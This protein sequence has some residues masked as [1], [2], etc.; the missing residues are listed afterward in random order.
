MIK[1]PLTSSPGLSIRM[2]FDFFKLF[3]FISCFLIGDAAFSQIP[4]DKVENWAD[5]LADKNDFDGV[6]IIGLIREIKTL[7]TA[8]WCDAVAAIEEH[9]SSKL[10]FR[11]RLNLL[12]SY[13]S[14]GNLPCSRLFDAVALCKEALKLAYQL[15]DP[16]LIAV[17]NRWVANAY[18]ELREFGLAILH[19][20]L[21]IEMQEDLG[22]QQFR[23][24]GLDH[25]MIGE[26]LYHA[27]EY[28]LAIQA[29][30]RALAIDA[31]PDLPQMDSLGPINKMFSWNTIGLSHE[32]LGQYDS[33][34]I[35]FRKAFHY[36]ELTNNAGWK[37]L[38]EGNMGDIYFHMAKYDSAE[39]FLRRDIQESL[40]NVSKL[41]DNAANSM[42]WLARIEAKKG[43]TNEALI[44][45]R[46][47]NELLKQ[48]PN[49]LF[50]ANIYYAFIDVFEKMGRTDSM[51]FY[52]NKY[53]VLH[54]SLEQKAADDRAEIVQVRLD[55]QENIH[56]IRILNKEKRRIAMIR[57]FSIA[58][59]LLAT[60]FGLLYINRQ[61]LKMQMRQQQA[62]DEKEKAKAETEAAR[63]QLKIFTEQIIKKNNLVEMLR[64]QLLQKE[65]T[66]QQIQ[67]I[68][69]LSQHTILT[70]E[71]WDRFKSLFEKVYPGFFLALKKKAPDITVAEQRIA[72]LSKLHINAKE[73]SNLLGISPASVNK[74]RQRLRYRLELEHDADLE[75]Y[76][77]DFVPALN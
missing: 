54:D 56:Q 44:Q 60:A 41:A 58:L 47:A 6:D 31:D 11:I 21:S 67:D 9:G 2:Q 59:T 34:F 13:F 46:K 16:Y 66:E 52:L 55:N 28:E 37:G 17:A 27:R 20:R 7:D 57:N 18:R 40:E 8:L 33:A 14:F 50:Q 53:I 19:V 64:E 45:L 23:Q 69:I 12:K 63:N 71:D 38:I 42:Q 62:I 5:R 10:R 24:F 48:L 35:A 72:A 65:L 75:L 26:M 29:N 30:Q 43:N 74:T 61:R 22:F 51:Y 77:A 3:I 73:A 39:Y 68:S 70:D 1:Y 4:M 49:P 25:Y 32:K 36:A 15:E 76:F